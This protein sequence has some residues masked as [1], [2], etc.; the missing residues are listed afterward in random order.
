MT[1]NAAQKEQP[2][3]G[4]LHA[5]M[6]SKYMDYEQYPESAVRSS[7]RQPK[8]EGFPLAK[9]GGKEGMVNSPQEAD[10]KRPKIILRVARK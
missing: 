4:E 2:T 10:G 1:G 7:L 5:A 8:L 6:M 9:T 3:E